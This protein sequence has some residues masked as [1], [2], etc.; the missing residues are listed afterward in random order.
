MVEGERSRVG[1]LSRRCRRRK[2]KMERTKSK[3]LPM[4]F[5]AGAVVESALGVPLAA[6][7]A[8]VI[9]NLKFDVGVRGDRW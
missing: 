1:G 3:Y 5:L 4:T 7:S 6:F 9:F 2:K 8:A